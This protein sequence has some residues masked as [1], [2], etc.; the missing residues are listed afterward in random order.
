MR[1]GDTF[2]TTQINN[3]FSNGELEDGR[4][5]NT[6]APQDEKQLLCTCAHPERG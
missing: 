4:P 1:T 5:M 2:I 3:I 6:K